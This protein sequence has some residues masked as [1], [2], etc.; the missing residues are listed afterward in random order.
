MDRRRFIKSSL[1]TAAAASLPTNQ[2]LAALLSATTNVDADIRAVTGD[3]AEVVLQRSAVQD[4]ANGLRGNLI[5]PDHAAYDDARRV[6]NASFDKHPELIDD[7]V[8]G[9]EEHP[10]RTTVFFWQHAGGAIARVPSD[11]TAYAHRN[12]GH[13]TM[14]VMDW[15]IGVDPSSHIAWLKRYWSTL[16]PH[17]DGFYSND[18]MEASASS[19]QRNFGRNSKR[20]VKLKN[21]YDPTNLFRMNANIEPTV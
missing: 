10:D 2:A 20:L 9:F 3:G 12:V 16:Q 14:V 15:K 18:L 17:T 4:L 5:L 21:T 7:V 6:I 11:A 1:V 13:L 19:V 8:A